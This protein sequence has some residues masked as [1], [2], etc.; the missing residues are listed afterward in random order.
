MSFTI[1]F[2]FYTFLGVS[3]L[4]ISAPPRTGPLQFYLKI[5]SKKM[6]GSW[7]FRNVSEHLTL[8]LEMMYC[9]RGGLLSFTIYMNFMEIASVRFSFYL[10]LQ[11]FK[12]KIFFTRS[13]FLWLL[14]RSM[15]GQ[16][17]FFIH[18]MPSFPFFIQG[19]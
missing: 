4:L 3:P 18:E 13:K 1:A 2:H 12:W 17:R 9:S 7:W 19:F 14:R 5:L 11:S 15:L 6:G 16:S 8:A 10:Y